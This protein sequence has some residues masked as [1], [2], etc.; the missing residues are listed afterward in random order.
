MNFELLCRFGGDLLFLVNDRKI[1]GNRAAIRHS[2]VSHLSSLG[3]EF[4]QLV[5]TGDEETDVNGSGAPVM[6]A[7]MEDAASNGLMDD[8]LRE[9]N[10]E[11]EQQLAAIDLEFGD[12]D[13]AEVA[14]ELRTAKKVI[15]MSIFR[16]SF[17][18]GVRFSRSCGVI[19]VLMAILCARLL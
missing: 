18:F 3:V 5:A 12:S 17:R 16:M 7:T 14:N 15:R 13:A 1:V 9:Y 4:W 10:R 11:F 8:V 2:V 6:S 19:A